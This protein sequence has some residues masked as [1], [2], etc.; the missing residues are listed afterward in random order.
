M[1]KART[2]PEAATE[3]RKSKRWLQVWLANNPVD[4]YG[5]PFCSR[6]GRTARFTL[7]DI[8]RLRAAIDELSRRPTFIYFVEAAGHIKIGKADK[9]KKRLSG[10]QCSLPVK[11]TRL[12][13]LQAHV[14]FETDLHEKFAAVRVRGEWFKDC[15][16]IRDFI[17]A[18]SKKKKL[19]VVGLE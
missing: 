4:A 6:L 1:S 10:I 19:F 9:W 12:L 3:L 18:A 15:R 8:N 11:L 7:D 5:K 16:E 17:E 13:V 14:G 2:L